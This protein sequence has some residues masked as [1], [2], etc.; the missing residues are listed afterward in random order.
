L[1]SINQLTT[2]TKKGMKKVFILLGFA[3]LGGGSSGEVLSN[4][5]ANGNAYTCPVYSCVSISVDMVFVQ[6]GTLQNTSI[7][8]GNFYIGKYEV[9]QK[10]WYEV[11]GTTI[12]DMWTAAGYSGAPTQGV[13][14]NYPMYCLSWDDAKAF[15]AKL[16][17]GGGN[18][19][20]PTEAEWEYAA[21]GGSPQQSYTYAGSSTIDSVA[22][23]TSNS[24][25]ATHPVGQKA[26]NGINA[27]DMSGNVR[28]WCEDWYSDSGVAATP[29]NSGLF[30]VNRGGS[31]DFDVSYCT[32]SN[33]DIITPYYCYYNGGFRLACSSNP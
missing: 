13:G 28:E 14:D 30:R 12:Q 11:M 21:R 18:F 31:C 3:L 6:G 5:P 32:V 20:L 8:V 25:D 19:R 24:G 23:C 27:H 1:Q 26:A 15:V 9:T 33:R 2:K 29:P 22:W 16:N 7:L 17:S 4:A 10:Q